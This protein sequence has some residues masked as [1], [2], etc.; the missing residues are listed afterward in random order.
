[1]ILAEQTDVYLKLLDWPVLGFV[2]LLILG[3]LFRRPIGRALS[4][5]D[6]VISWGE[7]RSITL[8]QLSGSL[9][10]ELDPLRDEL[11]AVK[12]AVAA[13][14]R[15]AGPAAAPPVEPPDQ[16]QLTPD[17]ALAA[18]DRMRTALSSGKYLWRSIERLATIAGVPESAALAILRADP[19]VVL[20]MGKSQRQIARLASRHA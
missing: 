2:L 7:N 16:G 5:G 3:F 12:A 8:G 13:L 11:E 10:E 14:E 17:Q 1:M 20:G 18:R 4:R 15:A 6:V 19:D 9:S